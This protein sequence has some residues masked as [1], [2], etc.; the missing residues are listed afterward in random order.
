MNRIAKAIFGILTITIGAY[1]VGKLAS[2]EEDSDEN[3]VCD[4]INDVKEGVKIVNN[5]DVE[6]FR[7]I[8]E[9]VDNMVRDAARVTCNTGRSVISTVKKV[10]MAPVNM[11]KDVMGRENKANKALVCLIMF[12]ATALTFNYMLDKG[13]R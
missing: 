1:V 3:I 11:I 10:T 13:I 8:V 7:I 2:K 4:I 5:N 6:K 9:H 12:S